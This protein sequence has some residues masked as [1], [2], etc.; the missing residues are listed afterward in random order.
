[1]SKAKVMSVQELE[2]QTESDLE[3]LVRADVVRKDLKRLAAA[4]KL[5]KQWIEE[6]TAVTNLTTKSPK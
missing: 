4:Q 1:M 6:A 2:W 3:A 5:A